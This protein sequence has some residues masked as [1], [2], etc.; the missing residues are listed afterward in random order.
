MLLATVEHSG[1]MQAIKMLG[2]PTCPLEE[3]REGDFILFAHLY[4]KMMP[5]I[6]AHDDI[7]VTTR[8]PEAAIRESWNRRGRDVNELEAQLANY[9]RLLEMQPYVLELGRWR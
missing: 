1:T 8:R 7:I 4:D 3:K 9:R 5:L 2:R 6:E